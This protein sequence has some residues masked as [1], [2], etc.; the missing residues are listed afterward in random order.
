MEDSPKT[1]PTNPQ[2][3]TPWG[4]I[5][6]MIGFFVATGLVLGIGFLSLELGLGG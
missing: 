4:L 6:I 5:L 2:E 3:G 1:Q